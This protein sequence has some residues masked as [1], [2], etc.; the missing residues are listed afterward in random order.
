MIL[1]GGSKPNYDEDSVQ[2]ALAALRK[3]GLP[4]GLVIDCSHGNSSKDHNRQGI[5]AQSVIEQRVKGNKAIIGIMLESHIHAGRQDLVDGK[6]ELYGV[7]V[8][9]ACIDWATTAELLAGLEQ[10]L[11]LAESSEVA[12]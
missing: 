7:S 12:A 10:Q 9:D 3:H 6:A 2:A 5:V 11:S 8:T 4:E 1:R